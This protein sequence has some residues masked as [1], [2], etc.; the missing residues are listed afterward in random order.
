KTRFAIEL[1]SRQLP[2]FPNGVFWVPL[3]ALRDPSLVVAT[4]AQTRGAKNGLAD[5]IGSR[6]MLLL[7]DNL[8]QVVEAAPELSK[9]AAT[10]PQLSLLVTSRELLRVEGEVE[11]PL[12]PLATDEAVDLFCTRA[13]SVPTATIEELCL[14]LDRLP[15]AIELAAARMSVF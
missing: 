9:L 1:A 4:I 10:C 8:E 14:R 5:H 7:L 11:F 2:R 13:W 3:V 6:Q 15:L 12:P